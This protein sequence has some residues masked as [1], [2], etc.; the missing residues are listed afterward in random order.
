MYTTYCT[1]NLLLYFSLYKTWHV[2]IWFTIY[3][4]FHFR[5]KALN[6]LKEVQEKANNESS[7]VSESE[8]SH[9][10]PIFARPMVMA[11][12]TM[13]GREVFADPTMYGREVI[14]L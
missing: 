5:N 12:P 13:Y 1:H 7:H 9:K 2:N 3:W 8:A 10:F 6:K 11:D 14:E 4:C